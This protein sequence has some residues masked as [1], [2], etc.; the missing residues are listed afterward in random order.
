MTKDELIK[1]YKESRRKQAAFKVTIEHLQQQFAM[2]QEK[3]VAMTPDLLEHGLQVQLF[4][5]RP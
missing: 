1:E 4:I 3:I 5:G 2:E